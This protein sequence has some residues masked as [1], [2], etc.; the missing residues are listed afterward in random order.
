MP[1]RNLQQ[2]ATGAYINDTQYLI[3]VTGRV[4]HEGLQFRAYFRSACVCALVA[5]G[6]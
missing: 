6:L 3:S 5:G 1:V 2:A 4:F